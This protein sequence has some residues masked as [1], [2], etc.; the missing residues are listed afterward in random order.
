MFEISKFKKEDKEQ[1]K[2][3]WAGYQADENPSQERIDAEVIANWL[4]ILNDNNCHCNALRLVESRQAIGFVT[5]VTHW[6]TTSTKDECCL[7]DLFVTSEFQG[8]GGGRLLISSVLTFAKENNLE[9][10]SWLTRD[11]NKQAQILYDKIAVGE[12]WIRYKVII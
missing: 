12:P 5:F 6:C 1:W 2:I 11:N 10:V 4:R 3:L 7:Y 9:E 8:K